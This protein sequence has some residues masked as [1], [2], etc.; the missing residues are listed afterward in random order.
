MFC[1]LL[2]FSD[3]SVLYYGVNLNTYEETADANQSWL[4]H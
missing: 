2:D 1:R 4:S 3:F